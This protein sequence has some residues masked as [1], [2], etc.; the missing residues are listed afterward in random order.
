MKLNLEPSTNMNSLLDAKFD[1]GTIYSTSLNWYP[2][3]AGGA[4]SWN[5][6]RSW[7]KPEQPEA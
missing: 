5:S 6:D 4:L 7:N 2:A 1:I 3:A